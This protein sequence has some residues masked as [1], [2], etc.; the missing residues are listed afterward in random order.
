MSLYTQ[1]KYKY[2]PYSK[3]FRVHTVPGTFLGHGNV[4]VNKIGKVAAFL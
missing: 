4:A 3:S 2:S 1:E